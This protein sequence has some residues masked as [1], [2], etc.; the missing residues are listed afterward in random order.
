MKSFEILLKTFVFLSTWMFIVGEEDLYKLLGVS[1]TATVKEI[2]SAYRRKALDT[3][4]DKN[5]GRE[6]E[7]AK[8]FQ[9]V[10]HA[11]EILSDKNSRN[12]YDRT[13]QTDDQPQRPSGGNRGHS[14][15][16]FSW[17]FSWNT[18]GGARY[19]YQRP[20]LKDRFDVKE[21]QSRILHLASLEQLETIIVDDD[22]ALERN[23]V[24]AFFTPQLEEHLMDE[25]VYPWPFAGMSSQ[26]IWWENLLQTT[27]VRFHRSNALTQFFNIPSGEEMKK[28]IFIFG[29]RGDAF[30]N[31]TTQWSRFET[32]SRT[33]FD[34]WMWDQIRVQ[35]E[36]VNLHDHPVE[37]YWI[38][39]TRA[40]IKF[41]L[42][43]QG[44][45]THTTMLSHEWWVRDAR[46]DTHPGS[47]GRHKLTT[48][49]NL[50][51][52]KITSDEHNQQLVIPL[53]HCFDISGHCA[54][55]YARDECRKNPPFM[56]EQ[57]P[58]TC[59]ICTPDVD[60]P[61]DGTNESDDHDE[62]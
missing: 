19:H 58:K 45:S 8:D 36:F 54:Y 20:K 38:H 17:S 25:M 12:R 46:T 34:K 44:R 22:G 39:G 52:W 7:A 5:K 43:P 37:V 6:E 31:E 48:N 21:S 51:H 55:W 42:P 23:L 18:G 9:K 35:V 59:G 47:P 57:C 27:T 60:P 14:G 50:Q 16:G 49:C 28:P 53:R 40:E 33:E 15:G 29:K 61:E 10:V 3:H 41:T 26:N 4:P 2:K 1:R 11:F 24:I 13:G 56:E 62:L 32:N 30:N